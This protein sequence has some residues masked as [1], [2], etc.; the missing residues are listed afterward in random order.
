[1][2][3]RSTLQ[4]TV[5]SPLHRL[6]PGKAY[7]NVT[8][9]LHRSGGFANIVSIRRPDFCWRKTLLGRSQ[10]RVRIK[11]IDFRSRVHRSHALHPELWARPYLVPDEDCV[12]VLRY[13]RLFNS[14][15]TR[16]TSEKP[17]FRL[18]LA[19]I[20]LTSNRCGCTTK[21]QNCAKKTNCRGTWRRTRVVW[22]HGRLHITL[23]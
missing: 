6:G 20:Y 8:Y 12:R 5:L 1:M 14:Y 18:P 2:H 22:I 11:T 16:R 4:G 15:S 19:M 21:L 9:W 10:D 7:Y 13:R 3:L 17:C 23:L